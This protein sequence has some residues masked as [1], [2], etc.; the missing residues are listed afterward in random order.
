MRREPPT[1][2][3][4]RVCGNQTIIIIVGPTAVGKTAAAIRLACR[5][6][7]TSF[8]PDSRQCFR[9]LNIGVAKPSGEELAV[10]HYFINSH[11]IREEVNAAVFEELALQWTAD[12][13][14]QSSAAIMVGGTGLYIK[15]FTGGLDE[16]P[17]ASIPPSAANS[18]CNMS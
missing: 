5:N 4:D 6:I 14:R 10:H 18:N 8:P 2:L 12:I 1:K 9:E 15:A 17:P 7:Q 16:I 3:S 13:F 11:S